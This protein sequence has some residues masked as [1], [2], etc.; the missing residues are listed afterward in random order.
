MRPPAVLALEA[1]LALGLLG[2]AILARKRRFKWHQIV[3][4]CV[5][6]ANLVVVFS[7]MIPS[8]HHQLGASGT[9]P[10]L[11][12]IHAGAGALALL[13]AVFVVV[14]AT[15][16]RLRQFK[17]WMRSALGLWWAA[18]LLGI[19]VYYVLNAPSPA[20]APMPAQDAPAANTVTIKNFSFTP[21]ELT[22]PPGTEVTWTDTLGRHTV[23]ADDGSF[24][25]GTLVANGT[26]KHKFDKPGRYAYFCE[27]HGSKGGHDM[28]G[29][30]IVKA[31]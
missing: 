21:A 8:L 3:Q 23:Q 26:F 9:P 16:G 18:F 24:K 2:G 19:G 14:A 25:S 17:P 28:A 20:P 11:L 22:V 1:L 12:W 29:V 31:P 13:V 4:T 6:L 27:F 30:V 10:A 5:V 15:L 7:V